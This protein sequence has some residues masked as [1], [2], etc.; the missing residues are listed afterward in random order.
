MFSICQSIGCK[1]FFFRKS[2][3]FENGFEPKKP[4]E[5]DNGDG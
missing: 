4:L 3:V 1:P 2:L 5:A